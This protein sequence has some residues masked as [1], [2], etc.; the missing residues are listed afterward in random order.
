MQDSEKHNA[1]Q[2]VMERVEARGRLHQA[3]IN[4]LHLKAESIQKRME[5]EL[6]I[7]LSVGK[8]DPNH[9]SWKHYRSLQSELAECWV[10][11]EQKHTENKKR[12]AY[13]SEIINEHLANITLKKFRFDPKPI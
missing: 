1:L 13:E 12:D 6:Q 4:S 11:V 9:E 8:E 3:E 7:A 10:A 5:M 2:V